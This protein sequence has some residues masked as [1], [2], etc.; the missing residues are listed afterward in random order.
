MDN[1][2]LALVIW[3]INVALLAVLAFVVYAFLMQPPSPGR[4]AYIPVEE[5]LPRLSEPRQW[6]EIDINELVERYTEVDR[7]PHNQPPYEALYSYDYHRL[8]PPAPPRKIPE[9]DPD[10]VSEPDPP[11]TAE[12]ALEDLMTKVEVVMLRVPD[13]AMVQLLQRNEQ[14]TIAPPERV[15]PRGSTGERSL[16]NT[17]LRSFGI[18]ADVLEV[19]GD[20]D[21]QIGGVRV[22][23]TYRDEEFELLLPRPHIENP[24]TMVR[25][26][27]RGTRSTPEVSEGRNDGDAD[28]GGRADED[29]T[30]AAQGEDGAQEDPQGVPDPDFPDTRQVDDAVWAIG[31]EEV[32]HVQ[33]RVDDIIDELRPRQYTDPDTGER[34]V[35]LTNVP[36]GSYAARRGFQS[37]DILKSINGVSVSSREE[38]IDYVRANPNEPQYRVVI[39]RV[40]REQTL[41]YR[42]PQYRSDD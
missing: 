6:R 8:Y 41:T 5:D 23:Y 16:V 24:F 31:P 42:N 29:A 7:R 14:V 20:E 35:R 30:A 19:V 15:R 32:E 26:E 38:A 9:P 21:A 4:P 17:N 1:R 13:R 22:L 3:T 18:P 36:S 11:P 2:P 37:G 39:L 34:H 27:E 12:E 10:P 25:G 28:G 33:Q 40:G